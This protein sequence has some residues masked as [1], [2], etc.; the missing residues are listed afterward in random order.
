MNKTAKPKILGVFSLAMINIIAIASL[1]TLPLSALYGFSLVFFYL[2]ATITFFIPTALV[3]AELAT[4]WPNKGGSYVWVRE[5][6]GESCGLFVIWI[7]WIYNVIWYPTIL[8]FIAGAIAYLI[9]PQLVNNKIFMLVA[10]NILFWTSTIINFYGMRASSLI[11]CVGAIIGTIIPMIF[12]MALGL[13]WIYFGKPIQIHFSYQE[14]F[15]RMVDIKNLAIFT[16]ILF[17]LVGIEMS[18]VHADE[19]KNP[20]KDYPKAILYSGLVIVAML[21]LSSLAVAIV[22]PN[23]KLNVVTGVVQAFEIF[24]NSYHLFWMIPIITLLI[25]IGSISAVATWI[26]GPTKGMYVACIDHHA[27]K[28]CTKV[29]AKNVPIGLLLLQG[30]I[31]TVLCSVFLLLPN[32]SSSYWIL[33]VMAAQLTLIYYIFIFAAALKLRYSHAAV[34][35]SFKIPGG[36][37]GIWIVT[38][39]GIIVCVVATIIG[40]FPPADVQVGNLLK[41]EAI[42]ILSLLII[43]LAPFLILLRKKS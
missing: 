27:P 9:N 25:I 3:S 18:A 32:V 6:F 8:S 38:I 34:A 4:A 10:I 12:I 41:F 22:V 43:C 2:I 5:A 26:V 19:V 17:A 11:S 36:K 40:F 31:F 21:T 24:F 15:P 14:F 16:A 33:T 30:V 1:R 20:A 42:L 39:T 23:E 37:I 29:N 28:I 13:V 35:R 7:Q